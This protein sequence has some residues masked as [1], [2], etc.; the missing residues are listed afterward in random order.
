MRYLASIS[1]LVLLFVTGCGAGI[2]P[3]ANSHHAKAIAALKSKDKAAFAACV[4]PAQRKGPIGLP[5]S[6]SIQADKKPSQFTLEDVLDIQFFC[7]VK[8]VSVNDDLAAMDGESTARLGATFDFGDSTS[9]VRSIVLKKEGSEWLVD[10]KATIEWWQS[11]NGADA[12]AATG[13][14]KK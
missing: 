8:D 4:L 6:L 7:E 13:P 3:E 5:D 12:F 10:L 9:A 11:M 14:S 2:P 1:L